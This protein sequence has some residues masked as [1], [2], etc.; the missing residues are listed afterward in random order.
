[1]TIH[2]WRTDKLVEDLAL[3]KVS[4]VQSLRY[5][6]ISALLIA[7]LQYYAYWLGGERGWF[8]GMEFVAVCVISL[9]GLGE[10]FKAN[11][12]PSGADFLRRMYCLGVPM[13][14]KISLVSIVVG[15][16]MYFGFP[17]VVT[18][19]SFRNPYFV[20]EL[21]VFFVMGVL[22]VSYYWRIAYHLGRIASAERSNP[23][24][25]PT[26]QERPAAD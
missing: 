2:W 16:V 17:R 7:A 3:G 14:L 21:A 6:M 10:C 24:M 22:T 12:G 5:A 8:L 19:T 26:G 4:E 15:Q 20:Y 23:L 9:I 13:G 11:G 25:Q 1:M 18:T